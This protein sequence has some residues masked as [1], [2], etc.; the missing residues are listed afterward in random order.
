MFDGDVENVLHAARNR[1]R[2]ELEPLGL[3]PEPELGVLRAGFLL[4]CQYAHDPVVLPARD[5]LR[6]SAVSI[7]FQRPCL[8]CLI[9][10]LT[11]FLRYA[12]AP[13]WADD[14]RKWACLTVQRKHSFR[15]RPRSSVLKAQ[16]ERCCYAR[17]YTPRTCCSYFKS[18]TTFQTFNNYNYS[19]SVTIEVPFVLNVHHVFNSSSKECTA[20]QLKALC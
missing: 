13:T 6:L 18:N 4:S 20:L 16:E 8:K 11:S 10:G 14:T 1:P 7:R 3:H 2:P 19:V 17:D 9:H 12:A 15:V 5:S